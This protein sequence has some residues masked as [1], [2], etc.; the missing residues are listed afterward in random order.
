M[1]GIIEEVFAVMRASGHGTYWKNAEEY[2]KAFYEK[3]L[4][5]TYGHRSSTLQDIERKMPTEIDSLNGVIVRMGER[6]NVDTPRNRV[7]TQIIKAVE[8]LY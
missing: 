8:A 1:N 7:I 4:P 5:P 6:F 3:I 2:R